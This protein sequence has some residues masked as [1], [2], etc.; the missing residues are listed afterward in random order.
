MSAE[1]TSTGSSSALSVFDA[2]AGARAASSTFILGQVMFLVAIALA[3]AAA[4]TYIGRNLSFR[5]A[6]ICWFGTFGMLLA[7]MFVPVLREG[8]VGMVWMF[9]LALLLGLG[10][11]PMIAHYATYDSTA[12]YQAA[13]GTA[14]TVGIMGS[15][16]FATSHDLIRWMRPLFFALLGV[17]AISLILILIGSGENLVLNLAIYVIV[18]AYLA[19]YFQIIRRQATERDVVWI[20]TGVFINIINI[21][22]TLLRIFGNG[23]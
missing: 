4:G 5:T 14:L 3:F 11:G 8:P 21:F 12:L 1:P 23:R 16:G 13:G 19:I 2:N 7:Q 22:L 9:A 17:F 6:E 15:Y 10:M 20:A 18:S